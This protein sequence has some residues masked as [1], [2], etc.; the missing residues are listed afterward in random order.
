MIQNPPQDF[1]ILDPLGLGLFHE[2]RLAL[3]Q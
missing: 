1:D 3:A 2:P